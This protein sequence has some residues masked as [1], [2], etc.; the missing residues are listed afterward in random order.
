[1]TPFGQMPDGRTVRAK[2][3]Q[4]G[5]LSVRV[6]TLGAI[7]QSVRLRHLGHDL[8]LGLSSVT[9]Y[10][11]GRI[12]MGSIVGPV[13]NRIGGA[14]AV[15]DGRELSFEPNFLGRHTLHSGAASV[16]HK[17]WEVVGHGPDRL[18]LALDLPDGEG[19]FPGKRRVTAE[20]MVAPPAT[21]RLV[22]T[23]TTDWPT[24]VNFTNHSYWNLDGTPTWAGHRLMCPADR[25]QELDAEKI[26]TG[27][28]RAVAGTALDLRRGRV[29]TPGDFS[30]DHNFCLGG[31][32]RDLSHAL[33]MTGARGTRMEVWTTEP[34]L[35]LYDGRDA[36][37]PG[38]SPCE[39]IAVEAQGWPDALNRPEFPSIIATDAAPVV[40]VT[41]WRFG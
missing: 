21:L 15:V 10:L 38:G 8:T 26:P 39:G 28:L 2:E 17:L 37:R 20:W 30:V 34:G 11:Q 16:C 13:A 41:E 12:W 33:T 22:I 32:R 24:P 6:L 31:A 5:A 1:M 7:L 29:V 19:G 23:T 18:T 9:D 35:Q 3:L 25:V 14:T 36:I 4:A 40:Q 27:R